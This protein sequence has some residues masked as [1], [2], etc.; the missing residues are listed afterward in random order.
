VT[1]LRPFESSDGDSELSELSV[2]SCAGPFDSIADPEVCETRHGASGVDPTSGFEQGRYRVG[3]EIGA[4]GMGRVS[5]VRDLRLL[6]DVAWKRGDG[7]LL[8]EAR[9]LAQLE[10]PGI[11]PIHDMG[12]D[13]K[14]APF[15]ALRGGT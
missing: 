2:A 15:F 4:G 1:G 12:F 11:V 9:I 3:R 5:L 6:R 8:R 13:R 14:G 7:R 10:H